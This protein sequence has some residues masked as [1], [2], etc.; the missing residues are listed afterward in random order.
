MMTLDTSGLLALFDVKD[1]DHTACRAAFD[2]DSGPY[3]ISIAILSEI[4]WFLRTR[5]PSR[6]EGEF[7]QDLR[8]G[9]YILDWDANDVERIHELTFRYHDLD[10][11]I[12]DAAVVACA[13]RH[14]GRVLSTDSRDFPVVARGEKTI[15]V[16]P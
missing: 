8:D 14:G 15:L 7:L 3:F 10:L 1:P 5:F 2:G 4:G 12:A 11:G 9:A 13:E 6:V 16:L